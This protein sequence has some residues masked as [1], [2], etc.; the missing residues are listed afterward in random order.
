MSAEEH[1]D[2]Q[3]AESSDSVDSAATAGD[4]GEGFGSEAAER[5][6][7]RVAELEAELL[8][9]RAEME[10]QRKRS[11][12]DIEQ[13]RR[14]GAERILGDLLQVADSLERGL[15]AAEQD[16]VTVE[17]LKEGKALT[18]SQLGKVFVS[19]GVVEE[20]PTG[21]PFDPELHQAMAMQPSAEHPEGT[22]LHVVQKGYRLHDRLLRPAMVVVSKSA[23]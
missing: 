12:R 9:V 2:P 14:F 13:A 15:Q 16:S 4:Q 20:D 5:L 10:N 11:L 18:L 19:Q 7:E 21:Q 17:T 3:Q 1:K 6:T 8:R 23:Q 22:V